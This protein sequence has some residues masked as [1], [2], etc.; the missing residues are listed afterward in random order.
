M[1]RGS[2]RKRGNVWTIL[3][4][5]PP[6]PDKKRL[7]RRESGFRT[8]REAQERLT[9]ALRE[10]DTGTSL[11]PTTQTVAEY[12]RHWLA[13]IVAPQKRPLTVDRYRTAI[14]RYIAPAI[15]SVPLAKLAPTHVSA[16]H[17]D[18]ARRGYTRATI[19]HT[20]N[21]LHNALKQAVRWQLVPRN[22]CDAVPAG[23]VER[24]EQVVW[25]VETAR[26]FQV[27]VADDPDAVLWLLAIATG[28]R[29]GELLGLKWADVDFANDVI[30]IQR[31]RV[32]NPAGGMMEQG[33]K[34]KRARVIDLTPT[35]TAMLR[36]HRQRQREL[37][38]LHRDNWEDGGWVFVEPPG[39]HFNAR[40]P[41]G[42]PMSTTTFA[43]RWSAILRAVG[44]P[45]IRPHDLR[46]TNAT[47][48]LVQG[49]HP[50]IVQERLG[51]ANIGETM[52]TYSHSLPT[53]GKRAAAAFEEAVWGDGKT[54]TDR[55]DVTHS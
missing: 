11:D 15:G 5:V 49:V 34:G 6:P 35:Q 8:K 51:H 9:A 50:K 44:L 2:L 48:L 7:Q 12:L 18:L 27:A 14:E 20:H 3:Y 29:R 28:L 17:A 26:R 40:R 1:A 25:D 33:T 22:A 21:A 4:D 24:A 10:V 52:D 37:M 54:V 36:A 47:V 23:K 16:L 39:H 45:V 42:R 32:R 55:A 46:H 43:R 41:G 53:L 19:V 38:M 31:A 13:T 30:R